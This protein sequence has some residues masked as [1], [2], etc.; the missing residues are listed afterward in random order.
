ML[1]MTAE[2]MPSR[3]FWYCGLEGVSTVR[4]Q[5]QLESDSGP[6]LAGI[7]EDVRSKYEDARQTDRKII[8]MSGI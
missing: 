3:W 5:A 6:H 1:T 7:E 2:A 8:Q 4:N